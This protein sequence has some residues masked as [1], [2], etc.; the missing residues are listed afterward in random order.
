MRLSLTARHSLRSRGHAAEQPRSPLRIAVSRRA[1]FTVVLF[2]ATFMDAGEMQSERVSNQAS[3]PARSES[4]Q[5]DAA[6]VRAKGLRLISPHPDSRFQP[7][8]L[9]ALLW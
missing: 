7:F 2:V 8:R 3:E 9:S 5:D 4:R 6:G 1:R